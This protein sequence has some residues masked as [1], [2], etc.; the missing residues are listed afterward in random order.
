MEKNKNTKTRIALSLVLIIILGF[1]VYGNSISGQ[2]IWD[3]EAL[4]KNNKYIR[5]WQNTP[6]IFTNDI[7][8]GAEK[9][10]GAYRPFQIL[11]YFIDYSLGK[12]N[13]QIYPPF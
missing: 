5:S 8:A 9:K 11:T 3:D 2:L 10:F 12:T 1:A 7:G 4:V 6:H 13:P